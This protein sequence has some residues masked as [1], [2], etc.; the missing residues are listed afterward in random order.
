MVAY[1]AQVRSVMERLFI[2]QWN[3]SCIVHG[4][5]WYNNFLY[6]FVPPFAR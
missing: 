3:I 4:D 2:W 6:R 1:H 5:A